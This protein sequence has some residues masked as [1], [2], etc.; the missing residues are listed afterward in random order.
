VADIAF[1]VEDVEA[2]MSRAIAHGAKVL[3]PIQQHPQDKGCL[4]WG[5]IAA[6]GS[7]THTLIQQ[8]VS[9][10]LSFR[11]CKYYYIAIYLHQPILSSWLSLLL[12]LRQYITI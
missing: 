10:Q 7:L 6:W 11:G 2:V 3:Q 12:I 5:K 1:L 8:S 4:K 9:A